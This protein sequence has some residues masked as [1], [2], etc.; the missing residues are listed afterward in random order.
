M[1][2]SLS[3]IAAIFIIILHVSLL[4][5]FSTAAQDN[6]N[7]SISTSPTETN[8]TASKAVPPQQGS[9]TNLHLAKF[10]LTITLEPK[11]SLREQNVTLNITFENKDALRK[12]FMVQYINVDLLPKFN[13]TRIYSKDKNDESF[14]NRIR[15]PPFIAEKNKAQSFK[16]DIFIPKNAELN[17]KNLIN[18]NEFNRKELLN[19]INIKKCKVEKKDNNLKD[20]IIL[21]D[22][23]SIL[24]NPPIIE[25][26]NVWI[27]A[28]QLTP[29]DNETLLV[30]ENLSNPLKA[31]FNISAWDTEDGK[32]LTYNCLLIRNTSSG[33]EKKYIMED[34]ATCG[35]F[36]CEIPI[37]P[38]ENYSLRAVVNDKN[39]TKKD[40]QVNIIYNRT[41]YKKLLIPGDNQLITSALLLTLIVVTII[42]TIIIF[43]RIGYCSQKLLTRPRIIISILITWLI[44]CILIWSVSLTKVPVLGTYL[45]FNT[46]QLFELAVYITVFIIIS[47]FIE[48]CFFLEDLID[49]HDKA[50]WMNYF[51]SL[52]ILI[53]FVF[54]I[55][56]IAGA[57]PLSEYYVTMSSLMGT[58]FALVVTLSTQYPKNIFTSPVKKCIK[59]SGASNP[60]DE[61]ADEEDL[62]SYPK[63]LRYFVSLY[64]ASLVISLLGLVIGTHIEFNTNFV[65][66]MQGNPYNFL[67]VA[68]FETT[69]LLVPPTVISLYHLMEVVSFRG[70][71]TI[72][73]DPPGAMVF[74]SKIHEKK[75][76]S[77]FSYAKARLDAMGSRLRRMAQRA[78][79]FNCAKAILGRFFAMDQEQE[80]CDE[81]L[82]RLNLC[83]PCTLMLM[84]GTY[85]LKL[86]TDDEET[87]P[88]PIPIRDAVESEL[89]IN[90]LKFKR[91]HK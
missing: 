10:G 16:Y 30:A 4:I 57:L 83:T 72:R 53:I 8:I 54:I 40:A 34:F 49:F 21:K 44:Y 79:E 24:N 29:M 39:N 76:S 78:S 37:Q 3:Y 61:S 82:H 71:I 20:N 85:N 52:T 28:S 46:M 17:I 15:I 60:V 12:S 42:I 22:D 70:K 56:R 74:L 64:G 77:V 45:F 9:S 66:P 48:A 19:I 11:Q 88:F 63:K 13:V 67:S 38:G 87:E 43:R 75:S 6:M 73:S 68:L 32:S 50:L 91:I 62:F 27:N 31:M 51:S 26:A 58:I 55:P 33:D 5:A 2:H 59:S 80:C 69:F 14:Q 90:R 23:I 65:N 25:T 36:S 84:R 7:L 89:T 86:Q 81:R 47:S 35:D 1:K 41:I 18:H